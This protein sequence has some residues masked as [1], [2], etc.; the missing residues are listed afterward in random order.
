MLQTDLIYTAPHYYQLQLLGVIHYQYFFGNF[1]G[2]LCEG[3]LNIYRFKFFVHLCWALKMKNQQVYGYCLFGI[4][5]DVVDDTGNLIHE[6][7]V[8]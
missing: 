1:F 3:S 2:C 7:P 8:V 4:V 6:T 5:E